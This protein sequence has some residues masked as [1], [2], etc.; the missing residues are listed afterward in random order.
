MRR[1]INPHITNIFIDSCAFDPKYGNEAIASRQL[2]DNSKLN[3]IIAHS[4]L[5]EIEHPN[6]P[7]YV[8]TL[9]QA[10]IFTI[11]TSLTEPEYKI[12]QAIWNVLTGNGKPENMKADAEHVFEAHKYGS[13]FI[14]TDER[15][16]R[17]RDELN[18]VGVSC[19]IMRPSE[20]REV[21]VQHAL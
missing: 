15:I 2:L 4:N 18:K 17:K 14:T 12:K 20:L 21:V 8:K 11:Q 1:P 3:L 7:K 10:R 9:A 13:Y 6:T 16:L 19:W 5:K